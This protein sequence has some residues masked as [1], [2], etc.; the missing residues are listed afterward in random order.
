M[1][2]LPASRASFSSAARYTASKS[3]VPPLESFRALDGARQAGKILGVVLCQGDPAIER[4]DQGEIALSENGS[5][6]PGRRALFFF[7][8]G[9]DAGTDVDQHCESQR[10]FAALSR[11]E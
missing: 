2:F 5:Q 1:A 11:K 8:D 9:S 6:K 4:D 3:D 7:E 10:Q